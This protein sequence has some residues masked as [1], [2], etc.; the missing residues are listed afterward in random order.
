MVPSGKRLH[1]Y[2]KIHH[3]EW[4]NPLSMAILNSYVK[5]PEG[6]WKLHEIDI[7]LKRT[8]LEGIQ[9]LIWCVHPAAPFQLR[10]FGSLKTDVVLDTCTPNWFRAY[11]EDFEASQS[12]PDHIEPSIKINNLLVLSREWGNYPQSLVIIIPAT[13]IPIHSLLSTSKIK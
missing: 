9:R 11:F 2:G 3:V 13:P 5:L 6:K 4:E 10:F 12:N 8:L 1:N 7:P